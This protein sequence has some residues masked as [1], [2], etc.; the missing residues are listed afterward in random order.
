MPYESKQINNQLLLEDHGAEHGVGHRSFPRIW[1]QLSRPLY[2]RRIYVART[3]VIC[4]CLQEGDIDT[5]TSCSWLQ[6]CRPRRRR[7]P[8]IAP[9][10]IALLFS[11]SIDSS[12]PPTHLSSPSPGCGLSSLPCWCSCCLSFEGTS[13]GFLASISSKFS[14]VC[15]S[16]PSAE[17][18]RNEAEWGHHVCYPMIVISV[19]LLASIGSRQT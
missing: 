5:S 19:V 8:R 6:F 10:R 15:C 14:F 13:G 1:R 2:I 12:F 17:L 16:T 9:K 11:G 18:R 7:W 4:N 3:K